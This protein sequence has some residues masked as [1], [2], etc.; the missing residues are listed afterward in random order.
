MIY[1]INFALSNCHATSKEELT[2]L[3][4]E[5][6]SSKLSKQLGVSDKAIE[7]WCKLYGITKPE[8]GYWAKLAADKK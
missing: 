7:K 8:R 3:V 6:P 1:G 4:W 2:K 5:M